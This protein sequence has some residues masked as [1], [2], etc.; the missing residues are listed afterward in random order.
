MKR[1]LV[2]VCPYCG[3][4]LDDN[5]ALEGSGISGVGKAK[6]IVTIHDLGMNRA[7]VMSYLKEL[8]RMPLK[9]LLTITDSLPAEVAK[10]TPAG[11][12]KIELKLREMGASVE[13][14]GKSETV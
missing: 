2:T 5:G 11:A 10:T 13:V 8:T 4:Y 3:S 6:S 7:Q 14:R 9:D 12:E 1:G